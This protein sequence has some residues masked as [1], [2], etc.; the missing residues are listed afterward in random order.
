MKV[1]ICLKSNLYGGCLISFDESQL[2]NQGQACTHF[3]MSILTGFHSLVN[4][5]VL[6]C[7]FFPMPNN[8]LDLTQHY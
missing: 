6:F 2:H 8:T 7:F 1:E 5:F 4:L 3:H